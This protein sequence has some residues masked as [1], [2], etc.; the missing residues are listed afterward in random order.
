MSHRYRVFRRGW[1]TFYGQDLATGKQESLRTRDTTE[2]QRPVA[3]RNEGDKAPAFSLQLA[4]VY[5]R[6]SDPAAATRTRQAV[7]DEVLRQKT[8]PTR[9]RWATAIKEAALDAIRDLVVLNA[10]RSTLIGIVTS[11][12]L[13]QPANTR[14]PMLV[15]P[16][17]IVTFVSPVQPENV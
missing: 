1:G 8:G 5:W 9:E 10:S 7:M 4:R 17:P 3:A 2:A 13:P 15:T 16:L 14:S 11:V 6:A 12:R